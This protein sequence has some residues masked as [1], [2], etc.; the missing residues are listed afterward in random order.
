[1]SGNKF[2]NVLRVYI[3]EDRCLYAVSKN[4]VKHKRGTP[5]FINIKDRCFLEHNGKMLI[6]T[7]QMGKKDRKLLFLDGEDGQWIEITP[8]R[9]KRLI[10]NGEEELTRLH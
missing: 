9:W 4:G 1:M 6:G 5:S 7:L 2:V 10:V 8:I 3:K